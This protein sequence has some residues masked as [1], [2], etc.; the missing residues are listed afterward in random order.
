MA[1]AEHSPRSETGLA[2]SACA[3]NVPLGFTLETVDWL[4]DSS[5]TLQQSRC[6][7]GTRMARTLRVFG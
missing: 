7:C 2:V 4:N 1:T 6:C 5:G 3:A